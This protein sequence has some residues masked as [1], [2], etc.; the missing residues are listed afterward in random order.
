MADRWAL[1]FG[2]ISGILFVALLIPGIFIGHP[3]VHISTTPS[4]GN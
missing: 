3:D 2:E 4:R 1:R